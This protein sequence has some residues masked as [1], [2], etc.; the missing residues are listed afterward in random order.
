MDSLATS[1]LKSMQQTG[2]TADFILPDALDNI[3]LASIAD[4]YAAT[5]ALFGAFMPRFISHQ[6]GIPLLEVDMGKVNSQFI[7]VLNG[8]PEYVYVLL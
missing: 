6:L 2:V 7:K 3:V 4:R 5:V 1:S 8:L